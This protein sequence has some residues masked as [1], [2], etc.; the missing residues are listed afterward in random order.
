MS[1]IIRQQRDWRARV[2]CARSGKGLLRVRVAADSLVEAEVAV[3]SV[4]CLQLRCGVGDIEVPWL[5]EETPVW[6]REEV[7]A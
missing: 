1:A 5:H 2:T 6:A 3:R 4:A 7:C